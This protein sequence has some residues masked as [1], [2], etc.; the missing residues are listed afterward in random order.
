MKK[1]LKLYFKIKEMKKLLL[2]LLCLPMIGFGQKTYVPNNVFEQQ[3]VL[4]GWDNVMDDSVLTSSINTITILD[5]WHTDNNGGFLDDI[6]GINDFISL[7]RLYLSASKCTT[8]NI[9]NLTQLTHLGLSYNQS[10]NSLDVSNNILLEHL[11]LEHN[12]NSALAIGITHLD[13]SCNINLRFLHVNNGSLTQ[14]NLKNGNNHNMFYINMSMTGNPNLTCIQ[15]DDPNIPIS[16]VWGDDPQHFYSINCGYPGCNNT[17]SIEER[18][19]NKE[20]LK[21][22][23]LL[24]RETPYKKR[25][26]LFYIY[27]DGTVEKRIIIE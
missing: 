1:S 9:S 18:S 10:L 26:P 15:V 17:A 16:N 19:T 4:G 8:I 6:T 24:G 23:D 12:Y 3:L 11:D 27:D 22:T 21:A 2:I 7:E 13:L 20:L 14:L 25:T 5:L